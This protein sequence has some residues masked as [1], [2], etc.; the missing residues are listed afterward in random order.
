MKESYEHL[1]RAPGSA[2][3]HAAAVNETGIELVVRIA[4]GSIRCG[5]LFKIFI[6]PE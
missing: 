1:N 4:V 3:H 6:S 5:P 2:A